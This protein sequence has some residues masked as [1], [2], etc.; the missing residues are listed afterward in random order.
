[1]SIIEFPAE[2]AIF[3]DRINDYWISKIKNELSKIQEKSPTL[4]LDD[5]YFLIRNLL[6]DEENTSS[7]LWALCSKIAWIQADIEFFKNKSEFLIGEAEIQSDPLLLSY[8]GAGITEFINADSG[9]TMIGEGFSQLKASKDWLALLDI[10]IPYILLLSN[11]NRKTTFKEI[12]LTTEQVFEDELSSNPKYEHLFIPIQ[13]FAFKKGILGPEIQIDLFNSLKLMKKSRNHLNI[14][15]LYTLMS[16]KEEDEAF[17]R[18]L[19]AAIQEFQMIN[20]NNRLI[21][22]YTNY[23]NYCASKAKHEEASEYLSKAFSLTKLLNKGIDSSLSLYPLIQQA[24]LLVE[25]G[26]L[27]EAKET[28]KII[29][30]KAQTFYCS[31]HQIKVEYGLAYVF[32]LESQDDL[33]LTHAKQAL[34]IAEGLEIKDPQFQYDIQMKYADFL[35]D[36]NRLDMV[37]S[38]FETV[39]TDDLKNCSKAYY[40][41]I[42]GKYEFRVHNIGIAKAFLHDAMKLAEADC[43]DFRSTLLYTLAEVY[44]NEYRLSE[45]SNILQEAQKMI[46]ESLEKLVGVPERTK[47]KCLLSIMLSAQGRNEEAEELLETLIT[48]S[49]KAIPRFQTLAEKLLENIH[50]SRVGSTPIS[51]ITNIRDA[52]RYLRDAKTMIDSQSR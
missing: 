22:A 21:I 23:A 47:G 25:Q 48:D 17:E 31:H 49:S 32:F 11:S 20:A 46:N 2:L 44:L 34:S 37:S 1:M 7:V 40:N 5:W 6:E 42:K 38:L 36:L 8:I 16:H 14:G 26:Q 28:F 35:I 33:A 29:L 19:E 45:D 18:H 50:K 9:I 30:E 52:L 15:L 41:Y 39:N 4:K 51:P 10:T 3:A 24:W 13:A 43:P 27:Q 12:Y